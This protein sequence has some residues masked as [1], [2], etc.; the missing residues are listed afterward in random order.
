MLKAAIVGCGKIADDHA[1]QMQRIRGCEIV[2]VCDIEPLMARQLAERFHVRRYFRE[3]DELLREARPDVVHVTTPPETHFKLAKLCLES[4]CHV[5]VEKPF[6]LDE[7]EAAQLIALANR[8]GLK[9]TAGHDDQFR[10]AAR[11]MRALIH[12]GYLGGAPVHMESSYCYELGDSAYANALLAD[13]RHW[14]RRLPGKLLHNIISHGIARIAE[15]L[16][17]ESPE[18]VAYGFISP[19]LRKI[20]ETEIIDELRVIIAEE[21]GPTAYFTFSSQMRPSLHEFRVYGPKNGLLL[22]Q[23][24][25]TLIKLRGSLYKSYLEKF[26]PPVQVAGEYLGNF[27]TNVSA[28]LR[29]DFHMKAGMKYL[30]ESFYRSIAEGT[31]VPIPYREILLTARIMDTIFAQLDSRQR[32][33]EELV[34]R[35]SAV[36]RGR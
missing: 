3:L 19:S 20:G 5:Y 23:D 27:K 2:G 9:I 21:G 31:P 17:T 1:S 26:V 24:Q 29:N 15:F 13:Q 30:I 12:S 28:F 10:N 14:I 7:R 11:R 4:G 33:P 36:V 6:T 18:V 16:T 25:E 32:R 8:N 35:T 34:A 22:N